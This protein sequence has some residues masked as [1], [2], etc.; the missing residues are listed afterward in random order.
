MFRCLDLKGEHR[1]QAYEIHL[2]FSKL[3]PNDTR[4][5]GRERERKR[6]KKMQQK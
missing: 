4:K 2:I 3:R 1:D 6:E 5:K